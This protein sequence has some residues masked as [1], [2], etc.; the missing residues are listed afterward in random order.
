V[1]YGSLGWIWVLNKVYVKY[2]TSWTI[3]S[4]ETPLA[5]SSSLLFDCSNLSL[6]VDFTFWNDQM[7]GFH[8]SP[9]ASWLPSRTSWNTVR[10]RSR[11][12]HQDQFLPV[13]NLISIWWTSSATW[14]STTVNIFW[15]QCN[16]NVDATPVATA[17]S[18]SSLVDINWNMMVL[19]TVKFWLVT[20]HYST[21]CRHGNS[22]SW[23]S[24]WI[25]YF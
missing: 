18:Y 5:T 4:L 9:S 20:Q 19:A 6:V 24:N 16:E 14:D 10:S 12:L 2:S 8:I 17:L 25:G 15:P 1:W 11:S 23:R 22:D 7:S 3:Y 21:V 13:A